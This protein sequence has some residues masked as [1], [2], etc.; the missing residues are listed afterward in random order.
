MSLGIPD[1]VGMVTAWAINPR[2]AFSTR[3]TSDFCNRSSRYTCMCLGGAAASPR[4][5]VCI[6][7]HWVCSGQAGL[8]ADVA[9][10]M[11]SFSSA[12]GAARSCLCRVWGVGKLCGTKK[13]AEQE[14][15]GHMPAVEHPDFQ[16]YRRR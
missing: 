5:S 11:F 12:E 6:E 10:E 13:E 4:A 14:S 16:Y 15:W 1:A 3:T 9:W 7:L 2:G 8:R